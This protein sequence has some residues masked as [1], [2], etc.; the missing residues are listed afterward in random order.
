M[1]II[2]III[3][4]NNLKTEVI[5]VIKGAT[6]T[7]SKSLRKYIS[8]LTGNHEIKEIQKKVIL[9]TAHVLRKVPM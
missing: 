3:I 8:N 4:I 2:I 1:M 7:Y 6:G 5:T 9:G